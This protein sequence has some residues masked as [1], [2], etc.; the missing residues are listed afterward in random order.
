MDLPFEKV[1]A[2][3][4]ETAQ[5]K[6]TARKYSMTTVIQSWLR[7]NSAVAGVADYQATLAEIRDDPTVYENLTEAAR[8]FCDRAAL[9]GMWATVA[10]C[11]KPYITLDSWL[12]LP[13]ESMNEL[14]A[15]VERLNPHWFVSPDQE[16]KTDEPQPTPTP[17]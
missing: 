10:A 6:H 4:I 15:A 14:T 13:E 11:V 2:W 12:E 5:M 8:E 17:D 3:T 1:G 9:A 7:K 16:K